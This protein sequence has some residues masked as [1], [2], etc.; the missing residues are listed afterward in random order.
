MRAIRAVFARHY[1]PR[2]GSSA[3]SRDPL[4]VRRHDDSVEAGRFARLLPRPDY[5]WLA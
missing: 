3:G 2:P 1:D 4:V 5:H